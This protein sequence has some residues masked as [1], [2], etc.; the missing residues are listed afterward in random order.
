MSAI[1]PGDWVECVYFQPHPMAPKAELVVGGVYQVEWVGEG[2]YRG[3]PGGGLRVVDDPLPNDCGWR[4]EWFRPV[5]RPKA[6]FITSLLAPA[7]ANPVR[8]GEPA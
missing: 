2:Q 4:I 5:Y 6:E 8:V 7:P 3:A 1:G